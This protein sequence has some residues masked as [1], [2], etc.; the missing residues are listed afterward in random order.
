[1]LD[2]EKINARVFAFSIA[3]VIQSS[4][5]LT[6]LFINLTRQ[7]SWF[8]IIIGIF[9]TLPFILTYCFIMKHYPDKNLFQVLETLFGKA[10]G[11]VLAFIYLYFFFQIATL[12]LH[13]LG[14]FINSTI[15]P[16]TPLILIIFIIITISA[17]AVNGG[18]TV[19]TKYS[20]LLTWLV[21][22][23][24]IFAT[25]LTMDIIKVDN[26]LPI[27][28]Y[29]FEKYLQSTQAITTI[30]FA[31]IVV[32]LMVTP[33][34]R[35]KANKIKKFYLSGFFM[36]AVTL[37]IVV[38]SSI[39]LLGES[40]YLYTMPPFEMFTLIKISASVSRMEI[41]SALAILILLFFKI[42]LLYYVLVIAIS[43]F[44]NLSVYKPLTQAIGLICAVYSM[45]I[46]DSVITHL[47]LAK[48]VTIFIWPVFELVIPLA[49]VIGTLIKNKIG[50]APQNNANQPQQQNQQQNQQQQNQQQ[51]NQ[52]QQNKQ[53]GK[54]AQEGLVPKIAGAVK[55]A[56]NKNAQNPQPN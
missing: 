34:I 17:Y 30:P 41:L 50:K 6:S 7:D 48:H 24:F 14:T 55:K 42:T 35:I 31:E 52:Q 45:F 39:A 19:V 21:L 28:E 15:M 43:Y 18:I 47:F 26:F 32:F 25:L 12:N 11:K 4:V 49:I 33:N 37:L 22:A 53:N 44:F 36:G 51:Q 8:V 29:P 9:T 16:N 40:I 1:M 54:N 56:K 13:D 2:N 3:C 23:I 46:Y 27:F 20:A 10:I 5:L 38:A